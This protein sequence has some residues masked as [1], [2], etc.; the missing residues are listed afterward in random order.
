MAFALAACLAPAVA[1][2][3]L[4]QLGVTQLW[5][6]QPSLTGKGVSVV[7]AEASHYDEVPPG[8]GTFVSQ[9]D[10]EINSSVA[11]GIPVTYIN[12]TGQTATAFPNNIGFESG[13]ADIVGDNF[14]GSHGAARGLAQIYN[15]EADYYLNHF[16][17]AGNLINA[18]VVNMSFISE[19]EKASDRL[20]YEQLLDNYVVQTGTIMVAAAAGKDGKVFFPGSAMNAIA[21][22]QYP[23]P[24][25]QTAPD[26]R[27]KPDLVVYADAPSY[28]APQVS[29]VAAVM[30]QAG[31]TLFGGSTTVSAATDPRT[32][33]AILLTGAQKPGGW[34]H[35]ETTPLDAR[36]GAGFA[37]AYTT[38]TTLA[39]GRKSATAT[40]HTASLGGAHD[41]LNSGASYGPS[42]WNLA[43]ISN[44]AGG[45]SDA[46]DHY[47]LNLPGPG[48][49]GF[50]A[51]ITWYHP[52]SQSVANG[53]DNYTLSGLNNLDLYLYN[54]ATNTRVAASTSLFDNVEHLALFGLP[55]GQ[56]DLQVLKHGGTG[57]T[58]DWISLSE[59][60]AI[61]W[62]ATLMGDANFDG[63]VNA[64]D[65][66]VVAAN[67]QATDRIWTQ[68]DF[69]N[70]GMVDAFDLNAL[71]ANWQA[72][73][74]G[75]LAAAMGAYSAFGAAAVPEP[76]S[77]L[78][79]GIAAA[80]LLVRRRR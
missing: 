37:Y 66:N 17:A 75:S 5:Q 53:D 31:V 36:Y 43:L 56:Y 32:I 73:T 14:F 21:V 72:G 42:G 30:V 67:W 62:R 29:G 40:T 50:T 26:G 68:G 7:L 69:N 10:F 39:A 71:A 3:D 47:L 9:E 52:I 27:S 51:T 79:L 23:V 13:H 24:S 54:A 4:N 33:K 25:V 11:N 15:I 77:V 1:R 28:A 48:A 58:S 70:D 41:A 38:Y 49:Y 19:V 12:S 8:S 44:Q 35:T 80:G 45:T 65:L 46:V 16:M 57:S 59:R 55:A 76:A 78:V 60:Y 22:A 64:F 63:A 2:A 18:R 20:L 6:V 74:A 61:A 34:T